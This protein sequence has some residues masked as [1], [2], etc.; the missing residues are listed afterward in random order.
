M[1]IGKIKIFLAFTCSIFLF[2]SILFS[3]NIIIIAVD[4]LRANHLGCY[5]YPR[6]TSLNID[7]FFFDGVK[8]NNCYT[9]SPLT[10][11]AFASV[12]TSL[13]P[14]KHGAER[15]GL[16]IF[17]Q[18]RTL[19]EFLKIFLIRKIRNAC[20]FLKHTR[21]LSIWKRLKNSV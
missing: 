14:Y 12:F 11:L 18:I 13:P 4:T 16:S 19:P 10:T 5:G 17:D 6:N 8:F 2:C 9:P 7:E 3:Q 1:I 15:N 20:C 21:V